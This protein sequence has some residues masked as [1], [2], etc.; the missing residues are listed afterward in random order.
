[1]LNH[2]FV[3]SS[4]KEIEPRE[5]LFAI[6]YHA[7]YSNVVQIALFSASPPLQHIKKG[8]SSTFTIRAK[9]HYNLTLIIPGG[10]GA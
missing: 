8:I 7:Y 10:G 9:Y 5:V 2:K 3:I 6:F 4:V 1:M